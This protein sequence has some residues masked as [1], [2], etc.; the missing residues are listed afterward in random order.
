MRHR[1]EYSAQPTGAAARPAISTESPN[2]DQY[3]CR[4]HTICPTVNGCVAD[5]YKPE[6]M[7]YQR[8]V[9]YE[10]KAFDHA[11]FPVVGPK[12]NNLALRNGLLDSMCINQ[13]VVAPRR[14]FSITGRSPPNWRRSRA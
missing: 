1:R 3:D 9:T 8:D 10:S 4:S 14:A 6:L 2:H 5:T 12:F 13:Q 7:P 11:Q